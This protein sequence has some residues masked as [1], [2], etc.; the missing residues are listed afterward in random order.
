M[1][2]GGLHYVIPIAERRLDNC[3]EINLKNARFCALFHWVGAVFH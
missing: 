1:V 3:I 2:A